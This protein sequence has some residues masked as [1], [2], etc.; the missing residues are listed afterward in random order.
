MD[1]ADEVEVLMEGLEEGLQMGANGDTAAT[2]DSE[3]ELLASMED[4][5]SDFEDAE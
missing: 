1:G 4:S 3:V 5:D 2:G